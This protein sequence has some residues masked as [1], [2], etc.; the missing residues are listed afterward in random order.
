M[1]R[2]VFGTYSKIGVDREWR[3][4][5]VRQGIGKKNVE[6]SHS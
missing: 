5:Y 1:K 6:F 2:L 4:A 3:E